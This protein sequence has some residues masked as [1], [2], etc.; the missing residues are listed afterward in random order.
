V[1]NTIGPKSEALE[2]PVILAPESYTRPEDPGREPRLLGNRC[3]SCERIFFPA[4]TLCPDCFE[5]SNP[6]PIELSG[7]GRIYASTIVRIPAPV[8]IAA[9][10]AYG[11][12]DLDESGVRVFALFSGAE[13]GWFKPGRRVRPVVETVR[14]DAN[15]REV[16][17]YKFRPADEEQA[18]E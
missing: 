9:P 1:G 5:Q 15:G 13:P 14:R 11:Y 4:R 3:P 18:N 16:I 12:V 6:I 8:G 7:R 17:G 2:N 10:Y